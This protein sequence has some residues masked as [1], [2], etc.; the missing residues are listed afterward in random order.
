MLSGQIGGARLNDSGLNFFN[1][2]DET[3][4]SFEVRVENELDVRGDLLQI[5]HLQALYIENTFVTP[6]DDD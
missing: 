6:D 3:N 5:I 1:E 2:A 4:N